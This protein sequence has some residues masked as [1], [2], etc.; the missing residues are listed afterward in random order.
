[1]SANPTTPFRAGDYLTAGQAH[2]DAIAR[3][4]AFDDTTK[5]VARNSVNELI[6]LQNGTITCHQVAAIASAIANALTGTTYGETL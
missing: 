6:D 1:M 3:L 2:D 4:D 5:V